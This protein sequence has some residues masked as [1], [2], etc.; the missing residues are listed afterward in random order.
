MPDDTLASRVVHFDE[1]L[2]VSEASAEKPARP[3][4][5]EQNVG[6]RLEARSHPNV[7]WTGAEYRRL[8]A[9]SL[10]CD[11]AEHDDLLEQLHDTQNKLHE[12]GKHLKKAQKRIEWLEG[13]QGK[14]HR[15]ELKQQ[16]VDSQANCNSLRHDLE[17][18]E[19][20]IERLKI[21]YEDK[22]GAFQQEHKKRLDT[23]KDRRRSFQE[24]NAKL[25]QDLEE[26][27]IQLDQDGDSDD[28]TDTDTT[29]FSDTVSDSRSGLKKIEGKSFPARLA[30]QKESIRKLKREIARLKQLLE[31]SGVEG[32]QNGSNRKV[33]SS[34]GAS[35]HQPII[36]Q[37][38]RVFR[39]LL[40]N[41]FL[42]IKHGRKGSPH[43]TRLFLQGTNDLRWVSRAHRRSPEYICLSSITKITK[44]HRTDI[45][46]RLEGKVRDCHL[47][48]LITPTRTL[49]IEARDETVRDWM[50][51]GFRALVEE[52]GRK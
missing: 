19:D 17:E 13:D 1:L 33:G 21:D 48:S 22:I 29:N 4:R 6:A 20:E 27:L 32:L 51:D 14:Q 7:W 49:D 15:K 46:K 43:R 37:H 44:G 24:E 36:R 41:G 8:P 12:S 30:K 3:A 2:P 38:Q 47:F 35:Y 16:F 45:L 5:G 31:D 25:H 42:V 23:E 52:N 26:A 34:P 10:T 11:D 40:K 50:V 39:M 28:D 9:K 18:A